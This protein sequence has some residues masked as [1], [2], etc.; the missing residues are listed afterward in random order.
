M[1][2]L[3]LD[4]YR[5]DLLYPAGR[6]Y[7]RNTGT[8]PRPIWVKLRDGVPTTVIVHATHGRAGSRSENEAKYLRDSSAV[9]A[10]YL[11]ARDGRCFCILPDGIVAWHAGDC[12]D[13]FENV[14]SIG[15]EIHCAVAEAILPAQKDTL[16]DLLRRIVMLWKIPNAMILTHR[17]VAR[18]IGRKSDPSGWADS[19][20]VAWR[21]GVLTCS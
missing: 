5:K 11:I 18:P 8:K 15:I 19:E 9:S 10:H 1:A 2:L 20:F 7:G 6:G 13:T 12:I 16:A 4:T 17:A 21:D 14:H 3:I